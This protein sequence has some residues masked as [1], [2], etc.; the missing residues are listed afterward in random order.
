M[1][2]KYVGG[3]KVMKHKII[4]LV[5][6]SGSGKSTIMHKLIAN[7]YCPIVTNTTRPPRDNEK[8]G[9]DYNFISKTDFFDLINNNQMLEY[10]K[11]NTVYGTW[12]Y[13]SSINN[14]DLTKND[15]VIVLT[16]D[17]VEA[18]VNHFGA[19]NCIVFYIDCPKN[20]REK[21]AKSRPNF[22]QNEWNRRLATDKADFPLERIHKLC[23]FK[24]TNYDKPIYDVIKTII[25]DIK[26]WKN[27]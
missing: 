7:G 10:R 13:G 18:F 1:G 11:Y 14:I 19:E 17:G 15:Y 12:Y 5:G 2:R 22:N 27:E 8:D 25:K 16:L 26:I 6:K 20:I 3:K 23:N 9:V 21:R 24:I 4:I